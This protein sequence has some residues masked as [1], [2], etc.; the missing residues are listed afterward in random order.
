MKIFKEDEIILTYNKNVILYSLFQ[1]EHEN[2]SRY[3]SMLHYSLTTLLKYREDANY[4]IVVFLDS[5]REFDF[6]NYYHLNKF[7]LI[8]DFPNVIFIKSSY[9]KN[10]KDAWMSK[11]FHIEKIF[12]QNYEKVFYLDVDTKFSGNPNEIFLLENN[13]IY[14]VFEAIYKQTEYILKTNG[15][16]SG[17]ILI[18]K[19]TFTKIPNFFNKALYKREELKKKADLLVKQ[20]LLTQ[21]ECDNFYFFSEQYGPQMLLLEYGLNIEVFDFNKINHIPDLNWLNIQWKTEGEHIINNEP[22][23]LLHYSNIND[24]LILPKK[25]HTENM[26]NKLKNAIQNKIV[27]YI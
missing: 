12:N 9:S 8:K 10:H 18:H 22:K 21:Q 6:I 25:Y 24:Y 14:A 5:D 1:R 20:N 16:N 2:E 23:I 17:T 4:D 3:Y 19:E 11:W 7:N 13:K 26:K 27:F 15:M